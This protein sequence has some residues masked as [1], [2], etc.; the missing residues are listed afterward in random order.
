M[1][2]PRI[3]SH[4]WQQRTTYGFQFPMAEVEAELPV[5]KKF[6]SYLIRKLLE[7]NQESRGKHSCRLSWST[8]KD[9]NQ[10]W[11]Q[12]KKLTRLIRGANRISAFV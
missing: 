9:L 12:T 6:K 4:H 1:L 2:H 8:D 10:N 11:K 5:L 3:S 7:Q